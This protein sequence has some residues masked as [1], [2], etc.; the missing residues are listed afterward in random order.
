MM[1]T[2]AKPSIAESSPK[3]ISAIDDAAA[4]ARIATAPSTVIHASD[5]QDS[6]FTRAA[7]RA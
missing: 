6:S 4:P 5:S 7:T 3:P 2:D 1:I